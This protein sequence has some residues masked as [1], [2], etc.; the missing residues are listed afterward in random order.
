MNFF[1]VPNVDSQSGYVPMTYYDYD[2]VYDDSHTTA[3]DKGDN[4]DTFDEDYNKNE[5]NLV[6]LMYPK[7]HPSSKSPPTK[8]NTFMP[9]IPDGDE[10]GEN[11]VRYN[12][13][14]VH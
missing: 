3:H 7:E 2:S 9:I 6:D 8:G 11:E 1:S 12:D 10:D 4:E 14:V 5:N 13:K